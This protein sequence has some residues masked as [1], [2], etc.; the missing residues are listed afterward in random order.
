MCDNGLQKAYAFLKEAKGSLKTKNRFSCDPKL[1]ELI[2]RYASEETNVCTLE[3]GTILYRARIYTGDDRE[4]RYNAP[5]KGAFKGYGAKESFVNTN[6]ETVSEGRCNPAYIPYLYTATS[7]RCCVYEVRPTKGAY[8]SMAEIRVD[9][10]LKIL[11]FDMNAHTTDS[12]PRIVPDIPNVF[13]CA[14]LARQ[15]SEPFKEFGDY[16]LCQFVSEKVK[17]LGFDG[18]SFE[19]SICD[20]EEKEDDE[21]RIGLENRSNANVIIFN[22]EKCEAVSSKLMVV[23]DVAI[24]YE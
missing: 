11:R 23:Y 19:S 13:L 22:Y 2:E 17:G 10:P 7:E 15:F 18:L 14:Y 5:P 3:P 12:L 20:K 8:I 6:H 24:E 1:I 9:D 4:K 16:L 21:F